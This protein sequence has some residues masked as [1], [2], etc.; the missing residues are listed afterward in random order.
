VRFALLK[1]VLWWIC[2]LMSKGCNGKNSN[3]TRTA[4]VWHW[5]DAAMHR[6]YKSGLTR[7]KSSVIGWKLNG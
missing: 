5:I 6:A 7:S 4:T 3:W 1:Q 2:A